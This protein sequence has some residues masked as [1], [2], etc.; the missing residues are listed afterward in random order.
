VSEKRLVIN[1]IK[2]VLRLSL[3]LGFGPRK[4]GK[5]CN[6]SHSTVLDYVNKA[7]RA[8]LNWDTI[9]NTDES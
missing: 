3:N 1:K 7:K 9:K 6:I 5:I 8:N 4:I 2:E